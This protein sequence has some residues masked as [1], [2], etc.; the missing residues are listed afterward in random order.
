MRL[1]AASGVAAFTAAFL[2]YPLF[3]GGAWFWTSLGAV[4]A[5]VAGGLLSSR[6]T[7]PAWAAP[8]VGLAALWIFLTVVFASSKAWALVVPTKE[9]VWE[10]GRLLGVGWRD[11][12]RFA[13]PVPAT[14]GITLLTAGGVGIIAVAVDLVAARL[15]RAALAGLPLLALATVPATILPDPISWPAFIIAAL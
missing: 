5:V 2:L 7:L 4:L 3:Q 6:L 12:Q 1:T 8:L 15:R 11:I 9:S 14:D 10:L 13:A